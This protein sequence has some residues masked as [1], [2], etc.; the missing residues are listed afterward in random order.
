MKSGLL[1]VLAV[2][3]VTVLLAATA[4]A[5]VSGTLWMRS[6]HTYG[7]NATITEGAYSAYVGVGS[8]N[9]NFGPGQN[10]ATQAPGPLYCLDV[11]HLFNWGAQYTATR[12]TIPPWENPPPY[13]VAEAS[14]LYHNYGIGANTGLEAAAA[15]MALWE[16]THEA[17]WRDTYTANWFQTGGTNAGTFGVT[18]GSS[19]TDKA[20]TYLD[21]LKGL[22][23]EQVETQ[24]ATNGWY[25]YYYRPESSSSGQGQMG[26]IPEPGTLVLLGFG[27]TAVSAGIIRR[28]RKG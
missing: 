22:T 24:V 8:F 20:T 2:F 21:A 26:N 1:V 11:Y 5:Q 17:A 16:V 13:N 10:P 23:E 12:H 7:T 9:G 28:S 18:V 4:E 3:L 14:W 27:L 25:T 15:Q 19:Y 6:W